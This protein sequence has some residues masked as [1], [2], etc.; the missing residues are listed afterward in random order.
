[1][2]IPLYQV[3]GLVERQSGESFNI[4]ILKIDKA[5]NSNMQRHRDNLFDIL[6]SPQEV[7]LGL[8]IYRL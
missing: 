8:V 4:Q 7:C 1:M 6:S 5:L 3:H 2:S